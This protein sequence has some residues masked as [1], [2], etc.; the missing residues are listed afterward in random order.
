MENHQTT[1]SGGGVGLYI[2][3]HIRYNLHNDMKIFNEYCESFFIEVEKSQFAFGKN[4]IVGVMYRPPNTD[5]KE[6]N[7]IIKDLLENIKR[8]N[9]VCYLMDDYNIDLLN[10][11]SHSP[12]SDYN[13]IMYSNGFIPLI[14]CPTRV[15][16]SS[17]TIID[18]IFTNQF[19]SQSLQGILLTDI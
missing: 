6:F 14:T 4:I 2:N 1:K 16:Y 11:E 19:S 7:E 17:A 8:E 13:D 18:N 10:I 15:T 9:K 12:T 5:M 3:D